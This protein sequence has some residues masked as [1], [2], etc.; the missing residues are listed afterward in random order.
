MTALVWILA[1]LLGATLTTAAAC[2]IELLG[3]K[4]TKLPICCTLY[5]TDGPGIEW[6]I[7]LFWPLAVP[8]VIVCAIVGFGVAA[9][10]RALLRAFGGDS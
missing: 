3:L 9:I 10:R 8:F 1:Y 5:T 6:V 2:T 4:R 7:T